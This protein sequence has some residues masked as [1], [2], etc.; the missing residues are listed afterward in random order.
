M[1]DQSLKVLL[2]T[3]MQQFLE[4]SF[5]SGFIRMGSSKSDISA[6]VPGIAL[7]FLRSDAMSANVVAS[8]G[9]FPIPTF[10]FFNVSLRNHMNIPPAIPIP[11]VDKRYQMFKNR[12]CQSGRCI[13]KVGLSNLCTHDQD[14]NEEMPGF[15]FPFMLTFVPG[16]SM[17]MNESRPASMQ[18]FLNRLIDAVPE[19]SEVYTIKAKRSPK[20]EIG[21]E[22]GS[23]V[24]TDEC[25]SS[26]FGDSRLAFK[27]QGIDE[28]K[29]LRPEWAAAYDEGCT[30][31]CSN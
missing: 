1:Q 15:Q 24:T 9:L 17:T 8:E 26:Y 3:F 12:F 30:G 5:S 6:L 19:G 10:N 11:E 28:D 31:L 20:D 25:V 22:L 16:S 7:K 14:G 27:H 21:F 2:D 29:A 23:I 13:S 18:E 4:S